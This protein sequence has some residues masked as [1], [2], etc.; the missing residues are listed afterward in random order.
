LKHIKLAIC[1]KK[2]KGEGIREILDHLQ[3]KIDEL[4]K[5]KFERQSISPVE[6][7]IDVRESYQKSTELFKKEISMLRSQIVEQDS[8]I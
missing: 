8:H 2:E 7:K 1:H 4:C 6:Q 5:L 3:D